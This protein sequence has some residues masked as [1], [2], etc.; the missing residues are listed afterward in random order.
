M[1]TARRIEAG[2]VVYFWQSGASLL[3]KVRA[4][5]DAHPIG[6][7]TVERGPWADWPGADAKPYT[8][9][10][11]LE[12]LT[13]SAA[14]QPSWREVHD[15]TGLS[16]NPTFVRTLTPE[17][18]RVLD[19]FMSHGLLPEQTLNDAR[20]EI[21]LAELD[22][23]QR[24]QRLQLVALRQGQPQFRHSL[25]RAYEG[26]C[27]ITGTS[28]ESVLEAAHISPYKGVQTNVVP[29]GLLL[30]ADLHTLFD[31]FR[32]TVVADSLLV[33][34]APEL[35]ETEYGDLQGVALSAPAT[36]DTQPSVAAL[37][38]HNGECTWLKE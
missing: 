38:W 23:D 34:V 33:R 22:Q 8:S 27:A 5:E 17:Q 16:M 19:A 25:L 10:F 32:L 14:A 20:R 9:R 6:P 26:R 13:P 30:R 35:E 24:I 1:I 37:Q 2:D 31:I 4:L 7:S 28:V 12:V 11:R 36:L 21:V 15:A 18:Q 3:G 29:N